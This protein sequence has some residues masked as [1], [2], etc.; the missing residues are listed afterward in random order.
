MV[1]LLTER[2]ARTLL[3]YLQET[4]LNLYYWLSAFMQAYPI[5]RVR[6]SCALA[7]SSLASPNDCIHGSE[8]GK[9]TSGIHILPAALCDAVNNWNRC[10]QF[11]CK[12][13]GAWDDVSGETFLRT[14]L[15]MPTQGAKFDVV[16]SC[17]NP[18]A[19]KHQV[20]KR[21]DAFNLV[22]LLRLVCF[23]RSKATA[24]TCVSRRPLGSG[25]SAEN[26]CLALVVEESQQGAVAGQR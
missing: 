14:L 4:N 11:V 5:P 12:Q 19:L 15:S 7:Q 18:H 17:L 8:V 9:D 6:H 16:C 2:S 24:H 3:F 23:A 22:I 26:A 25:C 13:D 21:L 20:A 1:G 10:Q